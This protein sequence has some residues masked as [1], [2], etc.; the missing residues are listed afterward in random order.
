MP[1]GNLH[2]PILVKQSDGLRV[3]FEI[4]YI[5]ELSEQMMS[6][7]EE[8]MKKMVEA[9]K[10]YNHTIVEIKE[11]VPDKVYEYKFGNGDIQKTVCSDSDQ[12]SMEDSITIAYAKHFMGGSGR[13]NRS[14]DRAMK[15]LANQKAAEEKVKKETEA[16]K[17]RREKKVKKRAER[18]ARKREAEIELQ[19]EAYR[20]AMQSMTSEK[21]K[22][23]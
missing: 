16:A 17:I 2:T 11:I 1:I 22:E 12:F 15:L 4:Y 23:A 19:A 20:R 6:E 7:D 8:S 18:A 3:M 9:V 13:Y 10:Q 21:P 5:G 14:V